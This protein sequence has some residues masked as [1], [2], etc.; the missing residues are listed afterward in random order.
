[1]GA[2]LAFA[3]LG[4]TAFGT[5]I[6]EWVTV[7]LGV[8]TVGFAIAALIAET[9]WALLVPAMAR[10][11]IMWALALVHDAGY[12]AAGHVAGHA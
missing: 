1:M 9:V 6:F 8:L 5:G 2:V 3:V 7:T 11:V 12:L 4:R 10:L